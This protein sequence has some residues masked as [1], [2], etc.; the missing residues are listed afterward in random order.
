MTT[1]INIPSD[2][3]GPSAERIAAL[4]AI[5]DEFKAAN[6]KTQA[7][8]LLAAL[9]RLGGVSTYECSRH[10]DIYH[11]P[12]RKLN[13]RQAGYPVETA[14]VTEYTEAGRPHRIGRYFLARDAASGKG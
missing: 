8:C 10:L 4:H 7:A 6:S 9:H 1:P 14:W 3:S 13:L 5:R 2:G 12:A 11:A